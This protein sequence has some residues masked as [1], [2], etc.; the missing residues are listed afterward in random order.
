MGGKSTTIHITQL[1]KS[2]A[3][4]V[5]FENIN[6]NFQV[7]EKIGIVGKNGCG[8]TTF[9]KILAKEVEPDTGGIRNRNS[10]AYMPQDIEYTEG[11]TVYDYFLRYIDSREEYKIY[12]ILEDVN[13]PIDINQ[14]VKSLSGGEQKK[15]QL[16]RIL[17]QNAEVLLLDEPTNHLDQGSLELLQKCI[18]EHSG[19]V[20]FISH[21]RHFLNMMANKI[22]EIEK[23]NF[24]IYHGNYE[25]YKEEKEKRKMRQQ[26]EYTRYQKE[27]TKREDW[28]LEMRQRASV[29]VN[30]ALGRLIKSKEKYIEREVYSKEVEKVQN[31]KKLSLRGIG[32][33]HQGKLI[34][35]IKSQN[36]GF[37]GSVLIKDVCMEIRGKDRV[38]LAGANGSG[39]TTL[40]KYLISAFTGASNNENIKTGNNITFDYFDQHNEV[41]RSR[42]VV[43]TRFAKHIKSKTDERGIRSQL[44]IIGLSQH[45]IEGSIEDLSYG[46]KVKI[47]F[48]QMLSAPID[49]LILDEPTNH[50]DIST[51]ETIEDMLEDYDGAL[52]I[53]S[54]DQ[55]FTAK[56]NTTIK[57]IIKD[58]KLLQESSI[59]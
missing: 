59:I 55:Y 48:L 12:S 57:Y 40:I 3:D 42:E 51:R 20:L 24:I 2:F 41:L 27:K 36:I 44:A 32:G 26:E 46:Q 4:K 7:G 45:E 18:T 34:L 53:V 25:I 28:M 22:L 9:I 17:L 35:E 21:D 33:T 23:N 19:I 8:K 15:L 5:L 49:L 50:L 1:S 58:K 37:D 13:L 47:K 11:E 29:Y 43:Y 31:E 6:I 39:K 10:I 38:M 54:H 30:P 52:L 14:T 56:I 16:A